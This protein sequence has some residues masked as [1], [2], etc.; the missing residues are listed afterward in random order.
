M[1]VE[2]VNLVS[3]VREILM[4]RIA[5]IV[6]RIGTE[7]NAIFTDN[8]ADY[9]DDPTCL[10]CHGNGQ[11]TVFNQGTIYES[12]ACE[13]ERNEVLKRVGDKTVRLAS[14]FNS[15]IF[16][17]DCLT[18]YFLKVDVFN[19]M[20]PRLWTCMSHAKS[21]VFLVHAITKVSATTNTVCRGNT[22]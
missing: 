18:G 6:N 22:V 13:C 20:I 5:V 21:N 11:C 16:C 17:K 19:H 12:I 10:G 4:E 8:E 14:T 15:D 1:V 2:C 3:N 7:Q 9:D